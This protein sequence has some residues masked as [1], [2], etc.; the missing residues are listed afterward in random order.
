MFAAIDELGYLAVASEGDPHEMFLFVRRVLK[1]EKLVVTKL[2]MLERMLPYYDGTCETQSLSR[3]WL[4]CAAALL[5]RKHASADLG[6]KTLRT[7]SA[8]APSMHAVFSRA[9]L[10]SSE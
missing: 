4:S 9:A 3:W 2:H 6:L 5:S 8:L 1:S 7:G 10:H